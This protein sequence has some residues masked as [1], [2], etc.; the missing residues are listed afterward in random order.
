[1]AVTKQKNS[2]TMNV[3]GRAL[4]EMGPVSLFRSDNVSGEV[5]QTY[6]FRISKLSSVLLAKKKHSLTTQ[7]TE[8]LLHCHKLLLNLKR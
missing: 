1:M 3:L 5:F 7:K 4:K 6:I 2:V 8:E